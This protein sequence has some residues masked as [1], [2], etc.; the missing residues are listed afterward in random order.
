MLSKV[1]EFE[2]P[3]SVKNHH[4]QKSDPM[5]DLVSN[6]H[7][8]KMS[9]ASTAGRPCLPLHHTKLRHSSR[10]IN[11]TDAA[12]TT[13]HEISLGSRNLSSNIFNSDS[14]NESDSDLLLHNRHRRIN[15]ISN[16]NAN[17]TKFAAINKEALEDFNMDTHSRDKYGGISDATGQLCRSRGNDPVRDK[18]R[19]PMSCSKTF[20]AERNKF[21]CAISRQSSDDSQK[22]SRLPTSS[23]NLSPTGD[24]M[25]PPIKELPECFNGSPN[26]SEA[27]APQRIQRVANRN[28]A[29]KN[30][31]AES[32]V[33]LNT[34]DYK[35]MKDDLTATKCISTQ[36]LEKLAA[37]KETIRELEERK[38]AEDIGTVQ[39][40]V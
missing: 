21:Q 37:V 26:R 19:R 27:I 7:A 1:D 11:C 29:Q 31:C 38:E 18:L 24:S 12:E 14:G 13:A 30:H 36:R 5:I 10:D 17:S 6:E 9:K 40:S 15:T 2:Q 4:S 3:G 28:G 34:H 23:S 33:T 22:D 8:A 16:A 20:T 32:A 25:E 39:S 35:S